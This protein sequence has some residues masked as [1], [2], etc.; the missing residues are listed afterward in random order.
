MDEQRENAFSNSDQYI[1]AMV[2][3]LGRLARERGYAFLSYLLDMAQCEAEAIV[4]R[5]GKP[6][7]PA[8]MVELEEPV[9]QMD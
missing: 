9:A 1:A 8:R 7:A 3:E 5:R 2:A 4:R 6:Q